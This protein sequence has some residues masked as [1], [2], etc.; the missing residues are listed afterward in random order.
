MPKNQLEQFN[1]NNWA[2]WEMAVQAA[3]LGKNAWQV[4]VD[5]PIQVPINSEG[6]RYVVNYHADVLTPPTPD[7]PDE[8]H[9]YYEK[10][11]TAWNILINSVTPTIRASFR[12]MKTPK[13]V[14]NY[15]KATY[16][17]KTIVSAIYLL[18][19]FFTLRMK[20]GSSITSHISNFDRLVAN[21]TTNGVGLPE[22][23]MAVQ[24]LISLPPNF[25][26]MRAAM[27]NSLLDED[28]K[29]LTIQRVKSAINTD[30]TRQHSERNI[31]SHDNA[32]RASSSTTTPSSHAQQTSRSRYPPCK[33]CQRTNHLH[34]V[35]WQKHPELMPKH[36]ND[37]DRE[38]RATRATT[39]KGR[40][41]E[42]EE[43]HFEFKEESA[44][45]ATDS[46][47]LTDAWVADGAASA[48]ITGQRHYF[49][50]YTPLS[51]PRTIHGI[52]TIHAVGFGDVRVIDNNNTPLLLQNV[53]Y[54]PNFKY[55]LF[56]IPTA[57][58]KGAT[59][60]YNTNNVILKLKNNNTTIAYRNSYNN[61]YYFNWK[62]RSSTSR[63]TSVE[64]GISLKPTTTTFPCSSS[65]SSLTSDKTGRVGRREQNTASPTRAVIRRA[66]SSSPT[67]PISPAYTI[68]QYSR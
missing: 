15:L 8:V 27:E 14:W 61:L 2:T 68:I 43:P 7:L 48:H 35:C 66:S 64:G 26:S 24:F 60:I 41:S 42:P 22:H 12:G 47:E 11:C 57:T 58:T 9:Q 65:S 38:E 32:L 52:N 49:V 51:S 56:S 55:N 34:N 3:I 33:H 53:L 20:E 5:D 54:V 29:K 36:N 45:F 23:V 40:D 25:A 17:K 16:D 19:E 59:A 31:L 28:I 62:L 39:I 21:L 1:G 50:S 18:Q 63:Y 30:N 10:V 67:S 13:Q 44:L 37:S 46:E 4:M 6:K